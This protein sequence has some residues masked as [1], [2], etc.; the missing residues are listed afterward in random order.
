MNVNKSPVPLQVMDSGFVNI[1]C[2]PVLFLVVSWLGAIA[3]MAQAL[4]FG[5]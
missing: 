5:R 4:N 1:V 2:L 3:A